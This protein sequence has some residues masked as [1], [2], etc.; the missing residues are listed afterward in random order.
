MIHAADVLNHSRSI[1]FPTKP[2][3]YAVTIAKNRPWSTSKNGV[4][5]LVVRNDRRFIIPGKLNTTKGSI[6]TVRCKLI[7]V[8]AR[9]AGALTTTNSSATPSSPWKPTRINTPP[10]TP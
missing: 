8:I 7:I 3:Q 4:S 5:V 6:T 1:T 9:Y 10:T 2:K